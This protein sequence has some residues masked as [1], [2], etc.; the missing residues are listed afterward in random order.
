MDKAENGIQNLL[1]GL[2]GM[3]TDLIIRAAGKIYRGLRKVYQIDETGAARG[4]EKGASY[5]PFI[6]KIIRVACRR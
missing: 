4:K 5:A 2:L 3:I 1:I 6:P